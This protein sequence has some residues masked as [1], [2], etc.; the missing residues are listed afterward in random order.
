MMDESPGGPPGLV[1]D[2][3][4]GE[5]MTEIPLLIVSQAG[6]R[7]KRLSPAETLVTSFT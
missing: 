4:A 6:Q 7:A 2:T 1:F 3:D 5:I